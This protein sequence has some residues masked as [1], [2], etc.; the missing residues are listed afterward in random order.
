MTTDLKF[1][2]TYNFL[3]NGKIKS[4]TLNKIYIDYNNMFSPTFYF[5]KNT[6]GNDDRYYRPIPLVT[7][8]FCLPV[9]VMSLRY[10]HYLVV[11]SF[12]LKDYHE[13]FALYESPY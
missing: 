13:L 7:I 9:P 12:I 2:L 4:N 8:W 11:T 1:N 10:M 3:L 6:F 5:F